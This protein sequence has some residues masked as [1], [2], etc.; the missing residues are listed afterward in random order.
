MGLASASFSPPGAS[1]AFLQTHFMR[2]PSPLHTSC[3]P[4][5]NVGTEGTQDRSTDQPHPILGSFAT[6]QA[7]PASAQTLLV[8]GSSLLTARRQAGKC[9][10]LQG[11]INNLSEYTAARICG[12]L[13]P[14]QRKPNSGDAPV[15]FIT[16]VCI[17]AIAGC[18]C[19]APLSVDLASYSANGKLH[20]FP[21]LFHL[22]F[23]S[24]MGVKPTDTE[25]QLYI[26][27]HIN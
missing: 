15:R 6:S 26:N 8:M 10:I 13:V 19:T 3:P 1:L 9:L 4:L 16:R 22:Q 5:Q 12:G 18:A 14:A 11:K 17:Q 21:N 7:Y 25:G 23:V 27:I 20:F 2:V 24:P